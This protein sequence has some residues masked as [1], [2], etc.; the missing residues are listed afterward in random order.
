MEIITA[1]PPN[2]RKVLIVVLT[3]VLG[4]LYII[5]RNN[6]YFH[7]GEKREGRLSSPTFTALCFGSIP[8][9]SCFSL[10]APAEA[11]K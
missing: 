11:G 3:S 10:L 1:K 9:I 4:Y 5:L 2:A 6:I 7:S 8:G